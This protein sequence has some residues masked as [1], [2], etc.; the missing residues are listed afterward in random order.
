M[1][2]LGLPVIDETGLTGRY[3]FKLHFE[4]SRP[5]TDTGVA[6]GP[7]PSIFTA[8]E[9]QLGLRLESSTASFDHLVVDSIDREP[10]GN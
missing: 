7:A 9:E 4:Q 1:A 2:Q 8:V 10:T 5:R 6:S 3:D